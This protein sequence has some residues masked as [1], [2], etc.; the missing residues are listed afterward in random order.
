MKP[1]GKLLVIGASA[2]GLNALSYIFRQI[3]QS[4]IPILVTKHISPDADEGM[5][6]GSE[7]TESAA[8]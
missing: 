6:K 3:D 8:C 1:N 4:S 7:K 5:L 2:G